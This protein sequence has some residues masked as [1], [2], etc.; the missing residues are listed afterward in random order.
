NAI[1][2]V[3]D[4]RDLAYSVTRGTGTAVASTRTFN[5]DGNKNLIRSQ[6]AADNNGDGKNDEVLLVYDGFDRLLR[7]V[8][9]VGNNAVF[10]YDPRGNRVR[11]QRFGLNGGPSPANNSGAGNVLLSDV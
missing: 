3:F 9:A 7:T 5:Y 11:E 1:E 4:E 2:R 8:D 6:D 10:H